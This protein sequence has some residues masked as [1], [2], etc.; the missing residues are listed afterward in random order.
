MASVMDS[1][2]DNSLFDCSICME[3]MMER[4]PRLLQVFTVLLF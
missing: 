2:A 3:D 4:N 1:A